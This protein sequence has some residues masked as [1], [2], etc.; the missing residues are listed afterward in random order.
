MAEMTYSLT[1]KQFCDAQRLHLSFKPR[2][3]KIIFVL[4]GLAGIV[5]LATGLHQQ[6]YGLALAGFVYSS[7]L[8]L[9]LQPISQLVGRL[10]ML[11]LRP[12][13][14]RTFRRSPSLHQQ[15]HVELRD[16]QLHLQSDNGSGTLPWKHII[17]WAEDTQSILLY[18]QP[19]LFIIVPKNMDPQQ[20]FTTPLRAQLLAQVGPPRT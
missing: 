4:V 19:R 8:L 7:F 17:Q 1:E 15:S 13:L 11:I 10:V 2:W 12:M 9:S 5:L 18:L 3:V 16:G 20:H 6:K 14:L